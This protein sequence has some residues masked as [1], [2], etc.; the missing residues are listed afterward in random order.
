MHPPRGRGRIAAST[1]PCAPSSLNSGASRQKEIKGGRHR[2]P[3]C[4]GKRHGSVPYRHGSQKASCLDAGHIA[5]KRHAR[6]FV[7]QG[8]HASIS[9]RAGRASIRSSASISQR[10]W[11]PAQSMLVAG[12]F[13]LQANRFRSSGAPGNTVDIVKIWYRNFPTRRSAR[14]WSASTPSSTPMHQSSVGPGSL[15]PHN[16]AE[17]RLRNRCRHKRQHA[18]R[19]ALAALGSQNTCRC[20][21][22]IGAAA[23]TCARHRARIFSNWR[24][25]AGDRRHRRQSARQKWREA[26]GGRRDRR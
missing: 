26:Q 4:R 3:I 13:D 16:T 8:R 17:F 2:L 21:A 20:F 6:S 5:R 23:K 12:G 22:T 15:R 7:R 14:W 19:A 9:R 10:R 1:G 24:P 25:G 18:R 11:A